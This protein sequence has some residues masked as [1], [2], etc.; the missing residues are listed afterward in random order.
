MNAKGIGV[1]VVAAVIAVVAVWLAVAKPWN[2]QAAT[3]TAAM[4]ISGT[5]L[6]GSQFDLA[7]DRGKLVVVNFF[8]EWCPPCNME[9]P[10]LAKF[11][12][13]HPEVAFVGVDENDDLTKVQAF[14]RKYG[15]PY[16]IVY[17]PQGALGRRYNVQGIPTT[18]FL[19]AN[20]VPRKTIVGATNLA[21]F[22]AAL[23][24]IE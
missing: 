22:E 12:K 23:A 20:G 2:S 11:A 8:A 5:T 9:A 24:S 6:T 14:V 4:Q 15:L 18:F 1:I 7:S 19:D 13:A 16:P 17:D 3:T 21:G 10:D